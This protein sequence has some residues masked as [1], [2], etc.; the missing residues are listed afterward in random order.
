M[1]DGFT[2]EEFEP[3]ADGRTARDTAT[4][5]ARA[6]TGG[7]SNGQPA[8]HGNT[9]NGP[10]VRADS[11]R[12]SAPPP[13]TASPARSSQRSR[14]RPRPIRWRCCCSS[15]SIVGNAIGRG[16]HF[17]VGEDRHYRQPLRAAGRRH[18]QGAQGPLGRAHPRLLH[19]APIPTGRASCIHRR[20]EFGRGRSCTPSATRS[21]P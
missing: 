2:A 14:R 10:G 1:S 9:A 8:A 17:Q 20:H 16:P 18:G 4:P 7:S 12:C 11:G 5:P 3:D 21:T 19:D 15:W 6:Q 13:I